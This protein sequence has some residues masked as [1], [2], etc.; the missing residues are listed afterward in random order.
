MHPIV[1]V[2]P[3]RGRPAQAGAAVTAIRETA[4]LIDTTV[5]IAVDRTDPALPAYEALDFPGFGVGVQLVTLAAEE[6][7]DLTRATNTV[8]LRVARDD[9][10]A[11]IGNLGD[12]HRARTPGWDRVI[13]DALVRPGIAY[14]DDG[15]HGER[16]PSAPFISA[17]I[18]NALGWYALPTCRHM[19]I[20]DVWRELG[21]SLDA[22]HYRPELSFEHLHPAVGKGLHDAGYDVAESSMEADRQAYNEWMMRW[23]KVDVANVRAALG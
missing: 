20:D 10:D 23:R 21:R 9:P 11:I 1:V 15:I 2:L 5:I 19:Y 22:L 16:L 8:S 17:A 3:S 18:V 12:D 13:R 7:G 4:S 14:G 6:T